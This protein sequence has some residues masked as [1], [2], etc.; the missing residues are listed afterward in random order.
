MIWAQC[1]GMFQAF[2]FAF[3]AACGGNLAAGILGA[4]LCIR[5]ALL[6]LTLRSARAAATFRE[7][8]KKLK[9][10]LDRLKQRYAN[11]RPRL[12]Q[13][14]QALFERHGVSMFSPRGCIGAILQMPIV[15]ALF[16][17]VR[18]CAAA[19]GRF[20]WIRNIARPSFVLTLLVTGLTYLSFRYA[21]GPEDS[22]RALMTTLA[23][24]MTCAVLFST[25]AGVA[26]YWAASNLVGLLQNLLLRREQ[27]AA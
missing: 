27:A 8:M 6:P 18:Q 2:I 20:F 3:A 16:F 21:P 19:G 26:L 24:V 1:V 22:Q 14:Q 15:F 12:L 5:L 10:E 13:E 23:T 7:Q 9:P 4:T 25:S 11:D 17:A